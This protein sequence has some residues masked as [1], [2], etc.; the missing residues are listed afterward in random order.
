MVLPT[1]RELLSISKRQ[2]LS[3]KRYSL[4][5]DVSDFPLTLL[6]RSASPLRLRNHRVSGSNTTTPTTMQTMPTG[7]NEKNDSL[8]SPASCSTSLITKLGGVPIRVSMPPIELAKASGMSS[9][10]AFCFDSVAIDTTMGSISATVPVLLTNAPMNAVTSIT[11][12]NKPVSDLPAKP[13]SFEP[14]IFASPV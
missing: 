5:S 11:N 14:T 9:R 4:T 13:I 2:T 7:R 1:S 10:E 6:L 12:T 8:P 3:A